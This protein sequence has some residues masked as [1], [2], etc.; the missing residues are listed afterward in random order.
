MHYEV[1]VA[2]IHRCIT[3]L[4]QVELKH[5]R[6]AMLAIVGH[7]YTTAGNRLPGDIAFGVPFKSVK[8]GLAAFET[9]PTAGLLQLVRIFFWTASSAKSFRLSQTDP[10]IT[11][12]VHWPA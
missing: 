10:L 7:L 5:G 1:I 3:F 11:V 4:M 6:I 9:I 12:F 8:A 2:Y